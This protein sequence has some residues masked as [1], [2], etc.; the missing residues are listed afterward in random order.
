MRTELNV[1]PYIG[2]LDT[3]IRDLQAFPANPT[4]IATSV[5]KLNKM[6]QIVGQES[7]EMASLLQPLWIDCN[8]IAADTTH[9]ARARDEALKQRLVAMIQTIRTWQAQSAFQKADSPIVLPSGQPRSVTPTASILPTSA[10]PSAEMISPDTQRNR[11]GGSIDPFTS[12]ASQIGYRETIREEA[13]QNRVPNQPATHEGEARMI[14]QMRQQLEQLH[15]RYREMESRALRAERQIKE[16]EA[17]EG[18]EL[19]A[20]RRRY[21]SE[22]ADQRGRLEANRSRCSMPRRP[23][24]VAQNSSG[25]QS[26]S[27]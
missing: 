3:I 9:S 26:G 2:V 20:M 22:W 23:V 15:S 11:S 17:Q 8:K 18:S 24:F 1:E 21:E 16:Q 27:G 6:F 10:S 14:D 4:Q 13:A 7:Q 19:K 12:V 25:S 5:T